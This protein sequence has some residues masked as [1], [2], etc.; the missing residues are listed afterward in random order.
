MNNIFKISNDLFGEDPSFPSQESKFTK[1]DFLDT[2]KV[3]NLINNIESLKEFWNKNQDFIDGSILE[4]EFFDLVPKSKRIKVLFKHTTFD[5]RIVGAKY[6]YYDNKVGLSIIYRSIK[7]EDYDTLL[8]LFKNV[9][10]YTEEIHGGLIT[11]KSFKEKNINKPSFFAELS[12]SNFIDLL[13]EISRI[14]MFS[15]PD[16]KI[17]PK[18]QQ[19]IRFYVKPSELKKDLNIHLLDSSLYENIASLSKRDIEY[20]N[21][22]AFYLVSQGFERVYERQVDEEDESVTIEPQTLELPS[23]EYYIGQIDGAMFKDTY[24]KDWVQSEDLRDNKDYS[25]MEKLFHGTKVA[26]LLV[27]GGD[28][29]D[30]LGLN[31]HC[32]HFRVKHFAVLDDY[33]DVFEVSKRIKKVVKDNCK[34]IKVWNVSIGTDAEIPNNFI[35]PLASV[36][37]QLQSELD[38]IF[39]VAATNKPKTFAVDDNYRIGSP[40]D[41]VNSLV[42]GSVR[43]TDKER[44]SYSRHGGSLGFFIKPDISFFG[45]DK[46]KKMIAFNGCQF[47][48]CGGTSYAAPMI[49]R[50]IAFLIY[51]AG[52]T[53]EEAKALIIHSAMEWSNSIKD[54]AHIGRGIVQADIVD[55]LSTPDDEIRFIYTGQTK[56]FFSDN[57]SLPIPLNSNGK[58][59][60]A[61]KTTMCY[62]TSCSSNFGVDYT[63]VEVDLKF[64]PVTESGLHSIKDNGQ[65]EEGRYVN[66]VTAREEFSKWDNLKCMSFS[67]PKTMGGLKSSPKWGFKLTTSYRNGEEKKVKKDKYNFPVSVVVT[68]KSVDGINRANQFRRDVERSLWK[69]QPIDVDNLIETRVRLKQKIIFK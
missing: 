4:V 23:N 10:S 60:F 27:H 24:L 53:R 9:L 47:V 19:F 20:I 3:N 44:A 56:A 35:S 50:K 12:N 45:G 64:G 28:I 58:T 41:S 66:E 46:D 16:E 67:G 8:K 51:H 39:V 2:T 43:M 36:L 6:N 55:I 11:A 32:G 18:D 34:K 17:E 1:N 15:V 61:V 63:N 26:S 52:F 42:V 37:D 69:I 62:F 38:V 21:K 30:S 54:I 40:A 49:A 13:L 48:K 22:T 29:N 31:D 7:L 65:Y 59:P 33:T 68:M 57:Y 14:R 5:D 25:E